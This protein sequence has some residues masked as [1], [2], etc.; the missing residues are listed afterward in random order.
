MAPHLDHLGLAATQAADGHRHPAVVGLHHRVDDEAVFVERLGERFPGPAERAKAGDS[1][2]DLVFDASPQ[3]L[4]VNLRISVEGGDEGRMNSF[5][6]V[7]P[8]LDRGCRV[9]ARI[10]Q[11]RIAQPR[12]A[13]SSLRFL[14]L[15]ATRD[16]ESDKS[17]AAARC[18]EL[19]RQAGVPRMSHCEGQGIYSASLA[20]LTESMHTSASAPIRTTTEAHTIGP[21]TLGQNQHSLAPS[22]R[23]RPHGNRDFLRYAARPPRPADGCISR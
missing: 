18:L 17:V 14:P 12:A 5:Q 10:A 21:W 8:V 2:A 15:T 4:G 3:G 19:F 1:G 22:I 23:C 16:R 6:H 13:R 11:V 20:F 9:S 7:G